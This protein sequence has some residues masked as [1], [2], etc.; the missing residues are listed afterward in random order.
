MSLIKNVNNIS[1]S[2]GNH[3][4][5][6]VDF[7]IIG[8][9]LAQGGG[10]AECTLK[11]PRIQPPPSNPRGLGAAAVSFGLTCDSP[12]L[13]DRFTGSPEERKG[14]PFPLPHPLRAAREPQTWSSAIS[15]CKA[16]KPVYSEAWLK[17]CQPVTPGSTGA[18]LPGN[19]IS[20]LR[21]GHRSRGGWGEAGRDPSTHWQF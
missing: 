7:T 1:L 16:K 20:H 21:S 13:T 6:I 15:S 2:A 18:L 10:W 11:N 12:Q 4:R 17:T 8:S 14:A 9:D 19:G 5:N 3:N